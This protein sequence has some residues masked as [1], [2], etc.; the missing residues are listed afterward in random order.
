[1]MNELI[2]PHEPIHDCDCGDCARVE[3]NRLRLV[4]AKAN[5]NAE[6]FEREWYLRGDALEK[7][8]E[9]MNRARSILTNGNPTPECN[10]GMLDTSD[11]T[12]NA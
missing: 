11:L 2:E 12:P 4:L 6:R 8:I 5:A 9:R 1:M 7:A 3:R 10:W